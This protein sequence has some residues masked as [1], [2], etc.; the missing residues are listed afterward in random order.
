V[1]D[2]GS[3]AGFPGLAIAIYRPELDVILL[4]PRQKKAAFLTALK[5]KLGVSNATV[6]SRRAE[7]CAIGDFPVL[8]SVLTMRGVN[9][10]RRV[11]DHGFRL[12]GVSG[13]IVLF[14]SAQAAKGTMEKVRGARWRTPSVVPWN[15]EHVVLV[16]EA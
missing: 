5:R 10:S 15:P 1:L 6:W 16:G 12:L 3:G 4:E 7:E 9:A 2:I 14:S 8:P 13:R 11:M